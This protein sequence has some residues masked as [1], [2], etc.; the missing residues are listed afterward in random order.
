MSCHVIKK[1]DVVRNLPLFLKLEIGS[2]LTYTCRPHALTLSCA[3]VVLSPRALCHHACS[4]ACSIELACPWVL[5]PTLTTYSSRAPLLA[6]EPLTTTTTCPC[7]GHRVPPSSG[8][9]RQQPRPPHP[10]QPTAPVFPNRYR[11]C[12]HVTIL[13]VL[14][15]PPV[16]PAT[17]SCALTL[18]V[19]PSVLHLCHACWPC[20]TRCT[21]HN[22]HPRCD[23]SA[24]ALRQDDTLHPQRRK[25]EGDKNEKG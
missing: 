19:W 21:C 5:S 23:I 7:C 24:R 15:R 8:R 11:V 17:E 2:F 1:A 9:N 25:E 3:W 20:L 13:F 6:Q 18:V 14:E 4:P 16:C 12:E 22:T 10:H